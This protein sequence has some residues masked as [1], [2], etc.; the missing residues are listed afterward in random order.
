MPE[1]TV[2]ETRRDA[3]ISPGIFALA[4]LVGSVKLGQFL[5]ADE[6]RSWLGWSI[7]FARA[8]LNG[9]WGDTFF[10]FA[11]GVTVTW[12]GSAGLYLNYLF[13]GGQA[14]NF[15]DF[16]ANL[17]F[18]P[19]DPAGIFWFRLPAVIVGA[20]CAALTYPLARRTVGP[21]I[22]L[23]G[24][25]LFTLDPLRIGMSRVLGTDGLAAAFMAVSTLSAL[26]FFLPAGTP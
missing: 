16:L 24:A 11:P 25:L 14:A 17:P 10:S 22:A 15:A 9:R 12:L 18:D 2:A 21:K 13:G 3:L 7:E 4:L 5:T 26:A 23:A 20:A 19:V 1:Q 8:L 6:P